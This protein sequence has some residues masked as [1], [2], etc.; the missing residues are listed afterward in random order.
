MFNSDR[1]VGLTRQQSAFGRML[2]IILPLAVLALA[3]GGVIAMGALKE[4]PKAKTEEAKAPPVVVATAIR[5]SASLDVVSEG[6]ARPV[7]ITNLAPQISGTIQ[8]VSPSLVDGGQFRRG[9]IL[10]RLDAR[11]HDLRITQAQADLAQAQTALARELSEADIARQDWDDLGEGE[12]SALTLRKPQLAEAKARVA[13][14]QARLG[15]AQLQKDRTV[16]RAPFSGRVETKTAALGGFAAVG[17]GLAVIY[18]T[19]AIEIPL[20]LTD[21]DLGRLGLPLGFIGDAKTPGPDVVLS[22]NIAGAAHEWTGRL[23]RLSGHF[24][25]STRTLTG[26]V[27]VNDPYGQ[28]RSKHGMPL[29]RGLYVGARIRG[30]DIINQIQVPRNALR[31]GDKVFIVND[32]DTLSIRTIDLAA[33]DRTHIL[34]NSGLAEG[35]R[36]IISPVRGAADGMKISPTESQGG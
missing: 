17:Q 33:T 22:A 34:I 20:P 18:A 25:P 15:E 30:K 8:Y 4:K 26:Y 27:I 7:Q 10:V 28:N 24:E 11:E 14:M 1:T 2:T 23:E 19:G 13:A 12:A 6:A 16:I 29:A 36:V 31:G 5:Q 3:V 32:D 21:K 35:E 9:D